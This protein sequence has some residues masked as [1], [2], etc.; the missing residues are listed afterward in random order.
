VLGPPEVSR[1][2]VSVPGL[3][4]GLV[5]TLA[6]H[7]DPYAYVI[8]ANI[9]RPHLTTEQ[10]RDLIAELIKADP[11]KSNRQIATTAKASPTTVGTVRA[12][13][14]AAGD[15]SKLDTSIDTK[16]RKQPAKRANRPK[17]PNP[18][19]PPD[20][21]LKPSH[22]RAARKLLSQFGEAPV[23]VQKHTSYS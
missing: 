12:K 23:E 8:S 20:A 3:T 7:I 19:P 22:D 14:E 16:G 2:Q 4:G 13:M 9:H 11:S 5:T 18:P 17:A 15:V 1:W 10:R 21:A 6:G